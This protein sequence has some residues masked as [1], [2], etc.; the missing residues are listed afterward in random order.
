MLLSKLHTINIT[1]RNISKWKS[2]LEFDVQR[3]DLEISSEQV[4]EMK[5]SKIKLF[6][7][8]DKCGNGYYTISCKAQSS[9]R[10]LLTCRSC[11]KSDDLKEYYKTETGKHAIVKSLE[12]RMSNP[13][14]REKVGKAG[15]NFKHIFYGWSDEKKK[16]FS[17]N[18]D[19]LIK[20]GTENPNWNPDKA[21]LNEYRRMVYRYTYRN[22]HIYSKWEHF[23]KIGKSE[24]DGAY[25]LDHIIPTKY[26]FDNGICPS[27]IGHIDNLQIIPWKENRTKWDKHKVN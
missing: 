2:Y 23:D 9:P 6:C 20:Y 22:K 5:V 14:W 24:I 1:S 10:K 12:T 8:C 7:A 21:E 3:G 19:Y 16:Q 25:Q 27:I 26:G 13:E 18:R 4:M 17:S 11:N 15:S